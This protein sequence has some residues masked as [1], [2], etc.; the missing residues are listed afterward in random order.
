MLHGQPVFDNS[1][2]KVPGQ[3]DRH[4]FESRVNCFAVRIVDNNN[5]NNM[6]VPVTAAAVGMLTE[7]LKKNLEGV[8]GAHSV[9]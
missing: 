4:C 8:P 7:G 1:E 6:I 2:Q 9:D 3:W 5:N